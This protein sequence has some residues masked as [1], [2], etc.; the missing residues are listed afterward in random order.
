VRRAADVVLLTLAAACGG[1]SDAANGGSPPPPEFEPPVPVDGDPPVQYPPDLYDRGVAGDVVLRVFVDSNG[2]V[3]PDSTIQV[4]TS[5]TYP[6]MDTAALSGV[7][8][9]RYAPAKRHGLPVAT[10]FLQ[11]VQFR[12]PDASAGPGGQP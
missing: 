5:S 9:L 10:W 8:A 2:V 12:P 1:G 4:T 6:R 3:V 7:R 11:P